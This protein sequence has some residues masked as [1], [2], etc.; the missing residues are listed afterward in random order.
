[1]LSEFEQQFQTTLRTKL[2]VDIRDQV[3]IAT[4]AANQAGILVGIRTAKPLPAEFGSVRSEIAPGVEIPRR[5]VRLS[6]SVDCTFV[7]SN[8]SQN[9]SNL[10]SLLGRVLYA[11]DDSDVRDGSAFRGEQTDPGF[12]IQSMSIENLESPFTIHASDAEHLQLT[13]IAKGWFWPVGEPGQAG[14]EIGEIRIRGVVHPVLLTPAEPVLTVNGPAV[15]LSVSFDARGTSRITSSG[16]DSETFGNL[17]A[18]L[19]KQDGTA[20]AGSLSGG[21]AGDNGARLLTVTD[22]QVQLSYTPPAT[23]GEDILLLSIDTSQSA[24]GIEIGRFTLV[25]GAGL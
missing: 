4:G 22:D 12:L 21:S 18:R 13:F 9:R 25:T 16:L 19:E 17:V 11:L 2:P 6:C 20:G 10:M 3:Q 24:S 14:V 1:M 8:D 7:P 23:P 15:N 5:V